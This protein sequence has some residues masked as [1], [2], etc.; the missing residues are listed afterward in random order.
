VDKVDDYGRGY[1]LLEDAK[2]EA[3]ITESTRG[4]SLI[5]GSE[6]PRDIATGP[7]AFD[8]SIEPEVDEEAT[9]SN[10][11]NEIGG[12]N[13]LHE[14]LLYGNYNE[15]AGEDSDGYDSD[16]VNTVM[17]AQRTITFDE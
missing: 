8:E 14:H 12:N 7:L 1:L 11:G 10:P 16:Y 17:K 13:V 6:V 15:D 3:W 5:I 2:L 4:R 9:S